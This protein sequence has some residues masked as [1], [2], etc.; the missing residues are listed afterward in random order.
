MR[1]AMKGTSSSGRLT[2]GV[3]VALTMVLSASRRPA[4]SPAPSVSTVLPQVARGDFD[5]DGRADVAVIR[6]T[7]IGRRIVLGLSASSVTDLDASVVSLVAGDVD[8]DGDLDLVTVSTSGLVVVWLN[9]G[10]GRF[11]KVALGSEPQ[12]SG[13]PAFDSGRN[14]HRL[15]LSG[16]PVLLPANVAA[17]ALRPS[18]GVMSRQRPRAPA[19]ITLAPSPRGPPSLL[20]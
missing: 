13:R 10:H 11:S 12:L 3:V 4:P 2:L 17:R 5:G 15:A 7:P 14:P 18:A 9:D 19:A 6:D 8:R 20:S 1:L 16:T